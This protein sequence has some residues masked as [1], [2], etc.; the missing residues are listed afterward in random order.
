MIFY[1][2]QATTTQ[3]NITGYAGSNIAYG[4]MPNRNYI[5]GRAFEYRVK[6]YL[7]KAGF[8]VM[9]AY[10]SKGV[11]DL[12]AV[13]PSSMTLTMDRE[14]WLIQCKTN[15]YVKPAEREALKQAS[16]L[17]AA[18]VVLATKDDKGH[19]VINRV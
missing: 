3:R 7:E 15:G 19:I 9:R 5:K 10:A 17:Y 6:K 12:I 14:A 8:Y 16:D 13:P 4:P 2:A 18:N 1:L 11:F